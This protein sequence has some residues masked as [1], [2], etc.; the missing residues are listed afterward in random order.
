M[1]T[2]AG[3]DTFHRAVLGHSPPA[4]HLEALLSEAESACQENRPD[5]AITTLCHAVRV[6]AAGG[7]YR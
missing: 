3:G 7:G 6:L 2:L 4:G 1:T 5:V